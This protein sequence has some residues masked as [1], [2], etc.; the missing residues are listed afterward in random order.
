[1]MFGGGSVGSN[2]L[3][4]GIIFALH[5][6]FSANSDKIASKFKTLEGVSEA[7]ANKISGSIDKMKLGLASIAVGGAILAGLSFPI[8]AAAGF[9]AKL[10]G[11]KAVSGATNAEM[12][13]MRQ[14]SLQM[15]KE[16]KYSALESA[17][18]IEELIKAG[19]SLDQV[20]NGGI[21]GALSL[22][23]A[24]EIE[25][26]DAAEI[27]STALN[28]FKLDALSVTQAADILAGAANAS[29]TAVMALKFGLS[30]VGVVASSM[31]MSMLDTATGLAVFAQNGLKGSDAGTSF[32][33]MLS[34]LIPTTKAQV[35]L[36]KKLGLIMADGSNAFFDQ[37]GRMKDLAGI[38]EVMKTKFAGLSDLQRKQAMDT[39]FGSDAVRASTILWKEGAAGVTG[40]QTSMQKFTSAQVAAERMN[41]FNGSVEQL[42]GSWETFMI[43][44]GSQFLKPLSI[45]ANLIQNVVDALTSI[46]QTKAGEYLMYAVGALGAL[47]TVGGFVVLA[48]NAVTWA[49]GMAALAFASLGMTAVSAAFAE[50]GLVAGSYA[51]ATAFWAMVSPLLPFIA[52]GAAVVAL[53]YGMYKGFQS[54][55]A[56]ADGTGEKLSGI[57]G[58]FQKI[59][60]VIQGMME[61][62]QSATTEGFSLSQSTYDALQ[63]LGIAELVVNIGTW[64]VR[65]KAFFGAIYDTVVPTMVQMWDVFK[66]IFGWLKTAMSNTFSK[67]G[68]NFSKLGGAMNTFVT[69]GKFVG[70][71]I[72][73]GLVVVFGALATAVSV[74]VGVIYIIAN[75]LR[76]LWEV[77]KVGIAIVTAYV[78]TWIAGFMFIYETVSAVVVFILDLLSGKSIAEA[79]AN[80]V[81]ALSAGIQSA[82]SGLKA[83]LVG[84]IKALPYGDKILGYVG[85]KDQPLPPSGSVVN[86]TPPM[87]QLASKGGGVVMPTDNN[88]KDKGIS[89]IGKTTARNKAAS[90]ASSNTKETTKET[91]KEVLQTVTLK[92]DSRDL[93][94]VMDKKDRENESRK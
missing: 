38:A 7:A 23:A 82:W 68:F 64:L 92:I 20:V 72:V 70:G 79:G 83:M 28:T 1:M 51:L 89:E 65:I 46:A 73:A 85:Y 27:A 84:L 43:V 10:S 78:K 32:K 30:Q 93:K 55:N 58:F 35:E 17:Q 29:A 61:I 74:A 56:M 90:S 44:V 50:S 52:V 14:L 19:I 86:S 24:G 26:A 77:I 33:T 36:S 40:M 12:E 13:T 66:G 88:Q 37:S 75:V 6:A 18:G 54:F 2:M 53:M 87:P 45:V 3:G 42:K 49:S 16:T 11:I 48:I 91:T 62:W 39:L 47:L 9:E 63:K 5:D 71:V 4:T 41:N 25:V 59:G 57:S 67:L 21:Q 80:F 81:N 60:G 76:F 22:A 31:R 15:G 8:E 69:V 94:T 34:N